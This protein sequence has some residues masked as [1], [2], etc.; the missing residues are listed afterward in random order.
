MPYSKHI[1]NFIRPPI[2]GTSEFRQGTRQITPQVSL[3]QTC[4]I[5]SL[6]TSNN[7]LC[8]N[9]SNLQAKQDGTF[10]PI[11]VT[12]PFELVSWHFMGPFPETSR[13]NRY[14]LVIIE[15]LTRWAEIVAIPDVIAP[16]IAS[17][18]LQNV[19]F[20]HGCLVQLLS[21]QGPHFH[22]DVFNVVAFQLDV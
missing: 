7:M 16:T 8:V 22:G 9:T 4:D 10:Q 18:L 2:I 12:S 19:N 14:I 17:K 5:M 11:T 21:D 13:G 1:S 15:Y 20:Q 3:T 6:P